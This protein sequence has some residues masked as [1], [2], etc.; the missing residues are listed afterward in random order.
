MSTSAGCLPHSSDGP[1]VSEISFEHIPGQSKLFIDFQ[2]GAASATVLYPIAGAVDQIA[3]NCPNVIDHYSTDRDRLVDELLIQNDRFGNSNATRDNLELLRRSD[4]V[5]VLT[6]QQAGLF[7]GP[8]FTI[9]KALSAI[10]LADRLRQ[11]GQNAVPVFWIASEDHDIDEVRWSG[12]VDSHGILSKTEIEIDDSL[13]GFPVGEIAFGSDVEIAI[14]RFTDSLGDASFRDEVAGEMKRLFQASDTFSRSFGKAIAKLLDGYGLIIVD[15]MS[16]ELRRLSAPIVGNVIR[17]S[18][19]I[20]DSVLARNDLLRSLGYHTQIE[21]D[22]SY[23]PLFRFDDEGKRRTIRKIGNNEFKEKDTNHR[24]TRAELVVEAESLPE[25]FSPS[26]IFRP[27]LQ[28]FLFP[29]A[30]YVGGAAEVSYFAQVAAVYLV[31]GRPITPVMHRASVT[32]I[33]SREKK[34]LGKLGIEFADLFAT[35]DELRQRLADLGSDRDIALLFADVEERINSELNRLDQRL[36]DFD[37][38]LAASLARRRRRMIYHIAEL[39]KKALI[40]SGKR[41]DL[42]GR[43]LDALYHSL[44]PNN[45]LQERFLNVYSLIA[46]YG[47]GVLDRIYDAIKVES[48]GHL[49]VEVE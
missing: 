17:N 45:E 6:G 3:A 13:R 30:C 19:D 25:R 11:L 26:V 16:N 1:Y 32:L 43:R 42:L 34:L 18:D 7:T 41:S 31:L 21:I 28:D 10:K 20:L 15:P 27:V 24:F 48:K 4:T 37:V 9:Y 44:L 46:R 12:S 38:T 29:T 47:V 5:A 35:P 40:E 22:E 8:I 49:L 2:N 23:F 33:G 14:D 39:R 36:T